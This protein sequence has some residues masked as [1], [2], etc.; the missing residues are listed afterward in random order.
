M[1]CAAHSGIRRCSQC[2]EPLCGGISS[3]SSLQRLTER[4]QDAAP[5]PYVCVPTP[6]Q[7]E[8]THPPFIPQLLSLPLYSTNHPG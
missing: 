5:G 8:I 4:G 2:T 7:R 6:G 1:A 3:L